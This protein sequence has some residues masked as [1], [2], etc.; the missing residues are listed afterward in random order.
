MQLFSYKA[1]QPNGEIRRGT[2]E[3]EDG[4]VATQSLKAQGLRVVDLRPQQEKYSFNIGLNT[5]RRAHQ[6]N[7]PRFFADLAVLMTAGLGFD[8]ALKAVS[9]DNANA[10]NRQLAETLSRRLAAGK[11]PSQA[12]A[13]TEGLRADVIALVASGEQSGRLAQVFSILASDFEL[14]QSQRKLVIEALIYPTFLLAVMICALLVIA[15]V[16]VPAIEP[17]FESSGRTAP[18]IFRVFAVIGEALI[19]VG[20]LLPFALPLSLIT[21]AWGAKKPTVRAALADLLLGLPVFGLLVRKAG[22]ARYLQSLA[23]L[24]ENGVETTNSLAL[25]AASCPV[26]AY[27]APLAKVRDLVLAGKRLP[28]AFTEVQIFPPSII[29]LATIGDEV[30]KLPTVLAN[31]STILRTEVKQQ[32]DRLLALLTPVVTIV[33]G[34]LVGSLVIS[35]MTALLSISEMSVQ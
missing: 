7:F 4:P 13:E 20:P 17:I 15:F 10:A 18:F 14:Q 27:K 8:R 35:V 22:L 12:L 34:G 26:G 21:A 1:F 29:S 9:A 32:I 23:L 11:S 25:A 31:A 30:N 16:L 28:E 5:W 19:G 33:M 6:A 3:A 24:L 2:I